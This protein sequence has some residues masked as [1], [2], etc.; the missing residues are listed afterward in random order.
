MTHDEAQQQLEALVRLL[1]AAMDA[2]ALP[3]LV[4]AL[5]FGS[6]VRGPLKLVSD[7]DLFLVFR[8]VPRNRFARQLLAEPLEQLAAP[9]LQVLQQGGFQLVLSPLV[10]ATEVL[11]RFLPI[12]L[13]L[14][15]CSRILHDPQGA[16]AALIERIRDFRTRHGIRLETVGGTRVWNCRGALAPG[17]PFTPEF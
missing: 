12:Y 16:G 8:S 9:L 14:P 11:Q 7:I 10:H 4:T 6:T 1:A 15:E 3:G 2:G 17:Q 13:D 5:Q